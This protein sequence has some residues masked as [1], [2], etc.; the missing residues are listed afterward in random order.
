[1]KAYLSY[2]S[3]GYRKKPDEFCLNMHKVCLYYLKKLYGEVHLIS[4]SCSHKYFKAL[5]FDTFSTSL[6]NVPKQYSQIWSLGKIYAVLEILKKG[7]PFIHVDY[8]VLLSENVRD[9]FLHSQVFAQSIEP[10]SYQW[11]EIDK[12]KANCPNWHVVGKTKYRDAFNMG[13]FGGHNLEFMANYAKAVLDLVLDPANTDFWLTY[14]EFSQSHFKTVI[15]EQFVFGAVSDLEN[16]K[17]DTL[18][19]DWASEAQAQQ[20]KY[21]HLMALKHWERPEMERRYKLMTEMLQLTQSNT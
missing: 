5:S 21:V 13:F 8:D 4:D 16:Q 6:D 1:M 17:V 7:D 9:K 20:E 2:W 11:Y 3:Q 19:K 18:Y 10:N 14:S 12:F 15:A